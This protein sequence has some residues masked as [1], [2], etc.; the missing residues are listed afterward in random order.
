MAVCVARV[1]ATPAILDALARATYGEVKDTDLLSPRRK[2]KQDVQDLGLGG[3]V[4]NT[5]DST[6]SLSET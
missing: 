6:F 5:G 4:K 2:V 1:A 3:W